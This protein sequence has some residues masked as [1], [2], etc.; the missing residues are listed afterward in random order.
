MRILA[1]A[2]PFLCL[3][4]SAGTTFYIDFGSG[5]DANTSVQAQSQSTP[6]KHAP[7]MLEATGNAAAYSV[8]SGDIFVLKGGVVWSFTD[9]STDIWTVQAANCTIRGGQ[10]LGSPWGT[11][12]AVLDGS[13]TTSP[14]RSGIVANGKPGLTVDGIMISNTVYAAD[15]SGNGIN[16]NSG[17]C[18]NWEIKNCY[19]YMCG[20]NAFVAEPA[21]GAHILF[22]NNTIAECGRLHILIDASV[23]FD[24]VQ[25][26][27][28]VMTG[29]VTYNP[30]G[31][32][33]DGFMLGSGTTTHPST[34]TNIKIHHNRFYGD[35]GQHGGPTALIYLNDGASAASS[36]YSGGY[37]ALIYDNQ[38]CADTGSQFSNGIIYIDTRWVDVQIYNNTLNTPDGTLNQAGIG[39]DH[40]ASD[41][42]IVI[43]NNI[44]SGCANGIVA[45]DLAH[46]AGLEADYNIYNTVAVNHYVWDKNNRWDTLAAVQAA[47]YEGHGMVATDPKFVTAPNGTVGAGNWSVQSSSPAI[48]AGVNLS[49][50]FTDD[51]N[52]VARPGGAWTIGAF[53][54]ASSPSAPSTVT[55]TGSATLTGSARIG[56]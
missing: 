45:T 25:L 8:Q 48:G 51:L 16:G 14:G 4:A 9:K 21:N 47:G 20:V 56:N 24:D 11:G 53:E 5:S 34:F 2:A 29:A 6:W 49:S 44:I 42:A 35:W 39:V 41:A 52:A 32:H 50:T 26:Y 7:G 28:N 46:G 15:G 27:S 22:H 19:F 37:H 40:E 33:M 31:Y 54:G 36:T 10:Q 18:S 38:L 13:T 17:D 23:T 55:I 12:Y 1:L 30:V 43:T 3:A